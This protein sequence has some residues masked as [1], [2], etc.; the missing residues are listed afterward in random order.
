[1]NEQVCQ[2][3]DPDAAVF[4]CDAFWNTFWNLNQLW[5]LATPELPTSGWD[6][7][8]RFMI[9]AAGFPRAQLASSTPASWSLH[10][11]WR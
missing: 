11:K 9:A 10:T 1:M 2:L 7:C 4:G 6:R 5:A 3:D 8:W